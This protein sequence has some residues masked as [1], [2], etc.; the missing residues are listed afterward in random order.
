MCLPSAA[1]TPTWLTKPKDMG[2]HAKQVA[3]EAMVNEHLL[4]RKRPRLWT[5]VCA[6]IAGQR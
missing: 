2:K 4:G 1:Y 6:R 5:L 3:Q